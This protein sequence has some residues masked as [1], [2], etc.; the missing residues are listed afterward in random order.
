MDKRYYQKIK[1]R[2]P[3]TSGVYHFNGPKGKALYV[4]KARNLAN[5]ISSYFGRQTRSM[6]TKMLSLA[7]TIV[8]RE[9]GSEIEALILES[10]LIKKHRPRF[11]T[12]LRDD[13]QYFYVF[14]S[15]DKFPRLSVN[16]RPPDDAKKAIGPFTDGGALKLTLKELRKVFPYCTCKQRHGR[17]CLN[18]HIGNCPGFCCLK[19]GGGRQVQAEYRANVKA[20]ADILSG[21][22]KLIIKKM[23][24][25]LAGSAT[26]NDFDKTKKLK[27]KIRGLRHVF[28]NAG[29]IGRLGEKKEALK[30]LTDFFDLPQRPA[31]IEGY[32]ISNIQGSFSVGSMVVFVNG[33]PDKSRYR[34]FKIKT[35]IGAN[36]TAM[37]AE[38]LTRRLNH[39]EWP[40][41]QLFLIDGGKGQLNAAMSIIGKSVPVISVSKDDRHRGESV[42][43]S[44]DKKSVKLSSLPQ[45]ARNLILTI[46]AEAHRFAINYYRKRHGFGFGK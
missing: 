6:I 15:N 37:L 5:R 21:K 9:T 19:N 34:K 12:M 16:H 18:Y 26:E 46:D 1:G 17:F 2:I 39:A 14:L 25:D 43:S 22:R 44:F 41:P 3:P 11:N 36:D 20:I 31:R 13:K 10:S 4:G 7:R 27:I 35:V 30:Q 28:E 33:Q 32:D 38:V 24:K 45:A 42:F 8:W 23:I 40:M 29:I